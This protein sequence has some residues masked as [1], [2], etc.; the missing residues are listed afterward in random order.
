MSGL[1]HETRSQAKPFLLVPAAVAHAGRLPVRIRH[2]G[3]LGALLFIKPTFHHSALQLQAII[4][5]LLVDA[6]AGAAASG[7][8]RPSDEQE[9]DE[10]G[11]GRRVRGG[12]GDAQIAGEARPPSMTVRHSQAWAGWPGCSLST[13][14]ENWLPTTLVA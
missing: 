12:E 3:D 6:V 9:V 10:G 13:A 11:A 2:Q 8:S 1:I 7:L 14:T 4:G 5:S